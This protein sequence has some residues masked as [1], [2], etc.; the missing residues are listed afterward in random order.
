MAAVE[1]DHGDHKHRPIHL[2]RESEGSSLCGLYEWASVVDGDV[3]TG[4]PD[5]SACIYEA[6]G[7]QRV[8]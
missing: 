1:F 2:W 3:T 4:W 6:Q 8:S 5:C 7:R